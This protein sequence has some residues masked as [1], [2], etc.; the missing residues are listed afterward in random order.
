M[1]QLSSLLSVSFANKFYFLTKQVAMSKPSL[2]SSIKNSIYWKKSSL[3]VGITKH[4]SFH[5]IGAIY[6]SAFWTFSLGSVREHALSLQLHHN[7]CRLSCFIGWATDLKTVS[8]EVINKRAE[9]T[10][11][12][13]HKH[14]KVDENNNPIVEKDGVNHSSFWGWG[15]TR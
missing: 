6:H 14:S 2:S 3:S 7:Y 13:T 12:G 15:K 10:G 5:R 11:D 9:R 4:R 8:Q 1:A